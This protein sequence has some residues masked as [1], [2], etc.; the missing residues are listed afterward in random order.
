VTCLDADSFFKFAVRNPFQIRYVRYDLYCLDRLVFTFLSDSSGCHFTNTAFHAFRSHRLEAQ[1]FA[2]QLQPHFSHPYF[3]VLV[4]HSK[5]CLGHVVSDSACECD[6]KPRRVFVRPH[7]LPHSTVG[8]SYCRPSSYGR[9]YLLQ[10]RISR[11]GC[12]ALILGIAQFFIPIGTN[13]LFGTMLFGRMFGDQV[14]FKSVPIAAKIRT[15]AYGYGLGFPTRVLDA[16]DTATLRTHRCFITTPV[17]ST[18]DVGAWRSTL[19]R[20]TLDTQHSM[21]DVWNA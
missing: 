20:P 7:N 14:V 18:L 17:L 3:V 9:S 21:L 8:F 16:A 19:E 2:C 13:L 10:W 1:A 4:L 12:L 11:V 6:C 5:P 15:R